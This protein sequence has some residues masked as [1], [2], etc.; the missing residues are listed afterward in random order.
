MA[1]L[2]ANEKGTTVLRMLE[3]AFKQGLT[4]TIGFSRTTGRNNVVTWNDIHHKTRTTG[5][6]ERYSKYET[7]SIKMMCLV[8]VHFHFPDRFGYP[9]PDYLERVREELEAKGITVQVEEGKT[10]QDASKK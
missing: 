9:D 8:Y 7:K 4:F 5:G 3:R 1:Y 2:P 6:P 10:G